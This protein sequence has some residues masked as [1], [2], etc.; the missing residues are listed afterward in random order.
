MRAIDFRNRQVDTYFALNISTRI[1]ALVWHLHPLNSD[2]EEKI[3]RNNRC[4]INIMNVF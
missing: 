1:I 3:G 2:T 4:I